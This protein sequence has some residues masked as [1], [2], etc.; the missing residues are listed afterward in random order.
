MSLNKKVMD[1]YLGNM[2]PSGERMCTWKYLA[3]KHDI[4]KQTLS[5]VRGI[6]KRTTAQE[7]EIFKECMYGQETVLL[8][9]GTSS[10]NIEHIVLLLRAGHKI[11]GK[12][13]SSTTTHSRKDRSSV[14]LLES[15][16]YYKIGVTL[17]ISIDKRITA[18]QGG[19]PYVISLVAKTGTISN[20]YE[21]ET[22]LHKKF[23]S[24]NVRGE[25]FT[26]TKEELDFVHE[27]FNG[28]KN[29]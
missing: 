27:T 26:L 21:I 12:G 10:H 3:E 25:W 29:A 1:V 24:N 2:G 9:N 18:L 14:Y 6:Q 22:M 15:A 23:E 16:G 11:V 5:R 20:A 7:F 8:S 4:N 13:K 19:N 17:D 28:A